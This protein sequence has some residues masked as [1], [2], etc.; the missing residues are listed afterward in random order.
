ML[1]GET[2]DSGFADIDTVLEER[3]SRREAP[4]EPVE[5]TTEAP[6]E[7]AAEE[8]IDSGPQPEETADEEP[9][10]A[11]LDGE[12]DQEQPEPE[13]VI[14]APEFWDKSGKEMFAKLSPEAKKQVAEYEKQ[15]TAAVARAMNEAAQVR[16]AAQAKQEQLDSR[17]GQLEAFVSEADKELEFYNGI[18]FAAEFAAA[19]TQEEI[20][21]VRQHQVRFASLIA[22]KTKAE[23]AREEA[24]QQQYREFVTAERETLA[25]LNPEL[26][27]SKKEGQQRVR[28]VYNFLVQEGMDAETLNWVPAV[29]L[30]L[31]YDAM[32]YRAS[33]ARLAES[34]KSPSQKPPSGPSTAPAGA[35]Q[36]S[37]SN[38]R[39][40]QLQAKKA[41][42]TEEFL[43]M[44]R[45]TRK[46]RK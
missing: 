46:K 34:V 1:D 41:L 25:K 23:K 40:G 24:T 28:E 29:G 38:K 5:D 32:R 17:I 2:Q 22:Q 4:A 33:K 12:D 20:D 31:A 11:N 45:L 14:E 16:K 3:R 8:E 39:L 35:S 13:E 30:N 6:V 9:E 7:A 42:S 10:E 27:V 36:G 44:R 18:D 19:R 21:N 37:P 15:R 26:D 43:E